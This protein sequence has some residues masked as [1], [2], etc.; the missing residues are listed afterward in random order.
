MYSTS[1]SSNVSSSPVTV[2]VCAV[3]QLLDVKVSAAGLTVP[4][5]GSPLSTPMVT[6]ASGLVV[7]RTVNVAVPSVPPAS[8]V[9]S[10]AVGLTV[11][12]G[13]PVSPSV[14]VTVTEAMPL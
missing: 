12:P 6:F 1:P 11:T 10:P 5:V 7:R 8:V 14:A 4:S 3:A 13:V 9:L 2:T